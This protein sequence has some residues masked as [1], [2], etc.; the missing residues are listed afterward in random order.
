MKIIE[1]IRNKRKMVEYLKE[2]TYKITHMPAASYSRLPKV[3][4]NES[5]VIIL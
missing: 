5:G 4:P 3:V 1:S 2:C